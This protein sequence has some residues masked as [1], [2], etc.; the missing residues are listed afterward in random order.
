MIR[1][2]PPA[3][4]RFAIG[5]VKA[6]RRIASETERALAIAPDYA[7]VHALHSWGCNAAIINGIDEDHE[8]AVAAPLLE[9][10]APE[11]PV[12][13]GHAGK[14]SCKAGANGAVIGALRPRRGRAA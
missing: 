12:P 5:S 4:T 6:I 7:L 14:T 13:R 1:Q 10:K 9:R 2:R 3:Q 8:L 11:Q